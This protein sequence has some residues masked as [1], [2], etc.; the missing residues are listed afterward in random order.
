M[1][2]VAVRCLGPGRAPVSSTW[3]GLPPHLIY[4]SYPPGVNNVPFRPC[5]R[6]DCGGTDFESVAIEE[7]MQGEASVLDAIINLSNSAEE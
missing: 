4:S 2:F 5:T 1:L 6:Q 7:G 3:L